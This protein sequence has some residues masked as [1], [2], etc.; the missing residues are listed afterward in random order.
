M[1][2]FFY[3]QNITTVATDIY[4]TKFINEEIAASL[5][6]LLKDDLS[7]EKGAHDRK[8]ST[9]DIALDKYY[10]DIYDLIKE[11]FDNMVVPAMASVWSFGHRP[12]AE[13]IFAVK[14]SKD[15]QTGLKEH[16]DE[17]YVSGSIKLNNNYTGG[18]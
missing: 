3:P 1:E 13:N 17:S 2:R 15:T 18:I 8:Y 4:H 5:V 9:H 14:Y 12:K 11:Q 7:W 16:I 10:P 6:A